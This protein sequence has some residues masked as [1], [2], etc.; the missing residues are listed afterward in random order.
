MEKEVYD[1][2][3]SETAKEEE[4]DLR[5]TVS[6]FS[7]AGSEAGLPEEERFIAGVA[8][9]VLRRV[10][11]A[12]SH[13]KVDDADIAIFILS[14]NPPE[15]FNSLQ[16][17][18]MLDNGRTEV[19]GRLWFTAAA[20]VS[21]YGV[22]LP[23]D[24]DD[25]GRFQFVTSNPALG[26]L[27]TV[28]YDPRPATQ[29]L[30]WYPEGLSNPDKVEVK[31]TDAEVSPTEVFEVI[32]QLHK[33]CFITPDGL[34]PGMHLWRNAEKQWPKQDAEAMMQSHL[35]AGLVVKF[36]FCKIRHEQPNTAGR[37]DLEID[38]PVIGGLKRFVS[39]ALLELKILRSYRSTGSPVSNNATA[40]WVSEGLKQAI[41]YRKE[42]GGN[43]SALCCFDMRRDDSGHDDTF[44]HVRDSADELEVSLWRWFL[45]SSAE[46]YRKAEFGF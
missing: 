5:A 37:T 25:A 9:L 2:G 44:D 23:K 18:P 22:E 36:P 38:K 19:V 21:A 33:E 7:G 11:E 16:W 27:P 29:W 10:G 34:P 39:H 46:A 6:D 31:S 14:P 43:W 1:S 40:Q 12:E 8:Q 41:A 28:I 13:C 26:S 32:D 4:D 42:V 17:E 45:H 30:R 20:V 3:P 24:S 35:K 15:S